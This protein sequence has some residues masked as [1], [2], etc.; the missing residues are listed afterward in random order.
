[1]DEPTDDVKTKD[2]D[3]EMKQSDLD[4]NG[5]RVCSVRVGQ[6]TTKKGKDESILFLDVVISM[7]AMVIICVHT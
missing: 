6:Q 1:M 4:L 2:A 5:D 3:V 7:L